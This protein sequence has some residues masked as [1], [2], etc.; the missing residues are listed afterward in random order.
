MLIM[1]VNAKKYPEKEEKLNVITHALGFFLGALALVLMIVKAILNGTAIHVVS[2]VIYGSSLSTLYF[3]STA[4][5]M[6]KDQEIRNRL[7]VFDH[8]SIFLLIAGTYTPFTLITLHGPWGWSIFGVVWGMAIV[9]IILKFFFTGRFNTLSTILYV[10]MGWVMIVAI[11]PLVRALPLG[12]LIWLIAGGLSYTGGA[13]IFL[14][15]EKVPY[16]HAV[17]HV[18][19]LLGSICHFVAIYWYVLP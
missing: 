6:A 13:V 2:V 9:G 1:K 14:M 5:H 11:V 16:N 18:F 7:N 3:A 10:L 4:Y 17:F 19:V 12:G 15:D 8:V